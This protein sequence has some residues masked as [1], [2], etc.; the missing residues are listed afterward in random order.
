MLDDAIDWPTSKA[1]LHAQFPFT[2]TAPK[3]AKAMAEA[4][5]DPDEPYKFF[6]RRRC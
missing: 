3:L 4:T 2:L 6:F 5:K 1:E